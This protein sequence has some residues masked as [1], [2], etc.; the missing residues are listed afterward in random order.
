MMPRTAKIRSYSILSRR[1]VAAVGLSPSTQEAGLAAVAAAGQ[2]LAVRLLAARERKVRVTPAAMPCHE[3][4]LLTVSALVAAAQAVLEPMLPQRHLTALA[5]SVSPV[6][7]AARR[8]IMAAV[9]AVES[10]SPSRA[11]LADREVAEAAA[12][13]RMK[14]SD[15]LPAAMERPTPA[16]V[17]AV[18][19]PATILAD[20]NGVAAMVATAAAALSSFGAGAFLEECR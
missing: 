17:A 9:A 1:V 13:R 20:S 4:A 14:A 2:E 5:V 3:A 12:T 18:V 8:S 7:S 6:R 15:W 11:R 10:A 16:A 19:V